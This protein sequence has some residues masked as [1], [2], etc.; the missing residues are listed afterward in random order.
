MKVNGSSLDTS[1]KRL[2]TAAMSEPPGTIWLSSVFLRLLKPV[3]QPRLLFRT[4]WPYKE[5][6]QKLLSKLNLPWRNAVQVTQLDGMRNLPLLR[7]SR[8]LRAE[9]LISL[10][11][12]LVFHSL[13]PILIA[14]LV[15][16]C[17]ICNLF[18]SRNIS[19]RKFIDELPDNLLDL[20]APILVSG[21]HWILLHISLRFSSACWYDP[22]VNE[23]PY[24]GEAR[25]YCL[26]L[27]SALKAFDPT[28]QIQ[29]KDCL[30]I[31]RHR[32]MILTVDQ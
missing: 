12:L 31:S 21:S 4:M 29:L 14:F 22:L 18:L 3:N 25:L 8:V 15:L 5:L 20:F 13:A 16:S 1:V 7:I 32:E 26:K 17:A 24:M 28:R 9:S 11:N 6:Y 19:I 2:L 30:M 27:I 10:L 23:S